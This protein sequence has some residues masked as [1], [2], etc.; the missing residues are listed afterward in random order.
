MARVVTCST[1]DDD[2]KWPVQKDPKTLV[3]VRVQVLPSSSVLRKRTRGMS[4]KV[5]SETVSIKRWEICVHLWGDAADDS[6]TTDNDD[7]DNKPLVVIYHG[8]L[9]RIQQNNNAHT[10]HSFEYWYTRY[11]ISS[12]PTLSWLSKKNLTVSPFVVVFFCS[13]CDDDDY[14]DYDS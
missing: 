8:F 3:Q 11:L 1:M 5:V 9:V 2:E 12:R 10:N 14:N 6:P 13:D 7:D 4:G